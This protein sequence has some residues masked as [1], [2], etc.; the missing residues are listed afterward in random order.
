LLVL[1]VIA[2]SMGY[3][4]GGALSREL[5]GWQVICWALVVA[6]PVTIPI[7]VMASQAILGPV[8]LTSWACFAYLSLM[9]QL[10]GF[11]AWNNGLAIGGVAKVGQVQLLQTFMTQLAS[12]AFIGEA[13]SLRSLAFAAIVALCVWLGRKA[14]VKKA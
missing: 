9:S 4:A 1:A 14:Q 13:L 8:S 3:A 2:A 12:A 6:L 10:V 7:A 5:G 11:F